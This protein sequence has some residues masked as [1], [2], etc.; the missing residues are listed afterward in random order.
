MYDL[1]YSET[2]PYCRKVI[3]F[4]ED[5]NIE[6]NPKEINNSTYYDELL[7]I[8][9]KMQV[10]FIVDPKNGIS[11]YESEDIIN[12]VKKNEKA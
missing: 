6:Y 9:K 3:K 4:F 8:G 5:N 12:Y 10:P 11:M 1:Y 7:D 2:C